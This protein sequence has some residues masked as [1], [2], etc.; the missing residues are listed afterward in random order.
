MAAAPLEARSLGLNWVLGP[1]CD[2]NNNPANPVINV[3]AW[4]ETA[5]PPAP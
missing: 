2:V 1:V 3:R 5:R 4:G